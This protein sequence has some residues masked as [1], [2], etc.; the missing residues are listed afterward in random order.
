MEGYV[1]L[2]STGGTFKVDNDDGRLK[3][4]E[5]CETPDGVVARLLD[6]PSGFVWKF[7]SAEDLKQD[8]KIDTV[9][10]SL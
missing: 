10:K 8:T 5:F 1:W 9:W 4:E 2:G 6:E 3:E 7:A